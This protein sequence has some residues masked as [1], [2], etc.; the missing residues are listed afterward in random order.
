MAL[1]TW[2]SRAKGTFPLWRSGLGSNDN[3]CI[4]LK[5]AK[6]RKGFYKIFSNTFTRFKGRFHCRSVHRVIVESKSQKSILRFEIYSNKKHFK[7][8]CCASII[9]RAHIILCIKYST[10]KKTTFDSSSNWYLVVTLLLQLN[11]KFT[12]KA[13]IDGNVITNILLNLMQT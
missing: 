12:H 3:S 8:F 6:G 4:L 10:I 13:G 9:F 11:N 7:Q 1:C 2:Y 5:F